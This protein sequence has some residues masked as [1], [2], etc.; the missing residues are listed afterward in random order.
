MSKSPPTRGS[1]P[2]MRSI[3]IALALAICATGCKKKDTAAPARRDAAVSTAPEPPPPPPPPP[4]RPLPLS[5][6]GPLYVS[7]RNGN[8]ARFDGDTWT[9]LGDVQNRTTLFVGIDGTLWALGPSS[10][11][12]Y[13][14]SRFTETPTKGTITSV[15]AASDGTLWVVADGELRHLGFGAWTTELVPGGDPPRSVAADADGVWVSTLDRTYHRVGTTW[16]PFDVPGVTGH[17]DDILMVASTGSHRYLLTT[18]LVMGFDGKAWRLL[19]QLEN[20]GEWVAIVPGPHGRFALNTGAGIRAVGATGPSRALDSEQIRKSLGEARVHAVDD[21]GRS[22]VVDYDRLAVF[23]ADG[24]LIK[25]WR[26]SDTPLFYSVISGLAVVAGG[27]ALQPGE[28]PMGKITGKVEGSA[29]GLKIIACAQ[30]NPVAGKQPCTDVP[31]ARSTATIAG[32][33]FTLD[34]VALG[35]TFFWVQRNG[36]WR[37]TKDIEC[38]AKLAPDTTTDVGTLTLR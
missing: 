26:D 27:P 33:R 36:R 14:G 12:R 35:P 11:F 9:L 34:G 38:C 16:T 6:E 18:R 28:R 25:V 23:G 17:E 10:V 24:K 30:K 8:V 15:A 19:E 2:L 21:R 32:G 20:A 5:K 29:A 1:G 13:D 22:W 7:F 31:G 3:W 4:P 37:A